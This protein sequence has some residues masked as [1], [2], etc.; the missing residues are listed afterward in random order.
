MKN[1]TKFIVF[2]L[3][4]TCWNDNLIKR[5]SE[6]IEIGA[7]EL[8]AAGQINSEFSA[9]IKPQ[10]HP[11]LSAFCTELTTIRQ[12]DVENARPFT[13]VIADFQ[14]W[15]GVGQNPYVLCSWGFYD[16]RQL[17][18]D[19]KIHGLPKAWLAPHI[20]LKH[21]HQ[22]ILEMENPMGMA[23]ALAMDGYTLDGTHH[24]GI[25]DAR[26][27]AKIFKHYFSQWEFPEVPTA[28]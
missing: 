7:L 3:E 20:S 23:G 13:E 15:I 22:T 21:Q 24:R 26:N 17:E 11:E 1:T 5:K 28:V 10:L 14:Q 9:F 16:R 18:S 25:D 2:D 27:I 19:C 8:D 12:S 6:I 4:A